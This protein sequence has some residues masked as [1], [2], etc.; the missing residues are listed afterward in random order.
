MRLATLFALSKM[1]HDCHFPFLDSASGLVLGSLR[2]ARCSQTGER[3]QAG[4]GGHMR[5]T[6]SRLLLAR[7][8]E[9]SLLDVVK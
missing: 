9:F 3:A 6:G 8:W 4:P 5:P 1:Q 7:L 2:S